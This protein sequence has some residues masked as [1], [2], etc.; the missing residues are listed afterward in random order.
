[1]VNRHCIALV[2]ALTACPAL[3]AEVNV[4][5]SFGDQAAVLVIDG[6][7]PRVV[8]V[9]QTTARG[10]T[11]VAIDGDRVTLKVDGQRRVVRLG[12]E[13]YSAQGGDGRQSATLA[14]DARGHFV[15]GGLVNGVPVRFVIDTGATDVA[16]P[17]S[18]ATRLGI[19][20]RKGQP[21]VTQTANG[22]AP[23]WRITLDRVKVGGIELTDVG[24]IVIEHGLSMA[25]LGMTFLNRVDMRRDGAT[26]VLTRRY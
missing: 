5:G 10:V 21:A 7:A 14:A 3:A 9:G 4:I 13:V 12:S 11:V 19:D 6:G 25:L 22:R 8:R 16:L 20:F 1:M 26:M 23:A 15:T 17:G 18:V 2:A 24:A